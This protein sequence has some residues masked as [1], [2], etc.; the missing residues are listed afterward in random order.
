LEEKK[1]VN[2]FIRLKEHRDKLNNMLS[3][4]SFNEKKYILKKVD[5]QVI[6]SSNRLLEE[7]E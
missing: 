3:R 4:L 7:S 2:K 5:E 6:K 1:I